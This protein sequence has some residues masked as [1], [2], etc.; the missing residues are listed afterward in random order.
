M[1]PFALITA[2]MNFTG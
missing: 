2:D 1:S